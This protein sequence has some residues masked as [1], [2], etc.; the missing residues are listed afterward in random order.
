MK[1]VIEILLFLFG[2]A[3]ATLFFSRADFHMIG[4]LSASRSTLLY[5]IGG[6][7]LVLG[8]VSRVVIESEMANIK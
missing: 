5:I 6:I 1:L 8:G 3:F 4:G 2:G 7:L